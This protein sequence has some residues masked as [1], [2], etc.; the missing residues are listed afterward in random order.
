MTTE[1]S[2]MSQLITML[3]ILIGSNRHSP[4][5]HRYDQEDTRSF[6]TLVKVD[7]RSYDGK[8]DHDTFLDWLDKLD[9]YFDWYDMTDIER[10]HFAKMK[11]AGAAEKYQ[12]NV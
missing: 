12:Q 4:P 8:L 9:D 6:T 5:S 7:V 3:D 2:I 10:V 1:D 11:L